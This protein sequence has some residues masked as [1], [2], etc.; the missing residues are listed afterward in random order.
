VA[1]DTIL[2]YKRMREKI[3][4][5]CGEATQGII[6]RARKTGEKAHKLTK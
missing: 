6:Y 5:I 1:Q 4:L 3:L 2:E